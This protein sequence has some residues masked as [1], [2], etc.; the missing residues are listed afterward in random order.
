MNVNQDFTGWL[1]VTMVAHQ[2][3][4]GMELSAAGLL[5][6]EELVRIST[7]VLNHC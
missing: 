7:V 3:N 5:R 2:S 4:F 1:S 6:G